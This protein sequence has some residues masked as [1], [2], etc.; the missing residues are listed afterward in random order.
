MEERII[1]DEYG[2]GVR[3]KKTKDGYV[4]VT[5]ELAEG[6]DEMEDGEEIAFEFPTMWNAEG[7]EEDDED[8]VDLSPEEAER[9]RKE[10]AEAAARR[11]A[12]YDRVCREGEE[13]LATG[14]FHAAELKYE[15]ALDLDDTATEASVGYWRAKTSDFA[16]PDVLISEYVEPGIESLEFELGYE[17]ADIIKH[18]YRGVFQR[19]IEELTAEEEPLA[20][21]VEEKQERRREILSAR[22]L[23]RGIALMIAALPVLALLIVTLVIGL[24][25][26]STPDS[27]YI[28]PTI[29]LACVT[30]VAFI[31]MIIVAN[32]FINACRMCRR[33]EQLSSTEEGERLLEIRE[34]KALYAAMTATRD[35]SGNGAIETEDE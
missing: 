2:R 9:V 25:N 10:K 4:D 22:R 30:F 32:R 7:M 13:L 21:S 19:R 28:T 24:K 16:D 23:H 33:N 35:D 5:D 20:K 27:R 3:L 17:A 12:E 26:F 8:L 15:K 6:A 18:K 34:Y 31:A 1:D 11:R 14:S 29:V